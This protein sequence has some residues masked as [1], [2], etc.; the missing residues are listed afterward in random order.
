[1][2]IPTEFVACSSNADFSS[3]EAPL[4]DAITEF[5]GLNREA[6]GTAGEVADLFRE[7]GEFGAASKAELDREAQKGLSAKLKSNWAKPLPA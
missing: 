7:G 6:I 1:M 2:P 4:R 5:R 3:A